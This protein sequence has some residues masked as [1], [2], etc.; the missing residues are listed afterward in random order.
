MINI[1][2]KYSHI[3]AFVNKPVTIYISDAKYEDMNNQ[4]S[5]P[6]FI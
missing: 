4:N 2:F 3:V 1:T 6:P 5:I